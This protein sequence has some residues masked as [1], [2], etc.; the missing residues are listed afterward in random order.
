M[1]EWQPIET[2]PKDGTR[3]MLFRAGRKICLGGYVTPSWALTLEGWKN[4]HGNFFEPTH[5]MPLPLP[6][7]NSTPTKET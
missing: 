2:A 3:V 5:W 6:P 4:S 7:T 1:S